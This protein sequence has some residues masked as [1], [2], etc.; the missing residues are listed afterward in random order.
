MKILSKEH[1]ELFK[2][3]NSKQPNFTEQKVVAG[4]KKSE[5]QAV[6]LSIGENSN[7]K[8]PFVD[9][10][11]WVMDNDT[12]KYVPTRKGLRLTMDQYASFRTMLRDEFPVFDKERRNNERRSS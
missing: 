3:P 6:I 5:N 7:T 12:E 10:R 9:I 1:L 4:I 8:L 11:L 2:F